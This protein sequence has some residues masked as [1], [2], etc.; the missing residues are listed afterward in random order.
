MPVPELTLAQVREI[1]RLRARHA[2][3]EVRAHQRPWGVIVEVRRHGHVVEIERFDF[4]G[5]T[6]HDQPIRLA[7]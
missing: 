3:A 7:A 1:A 4:D 5:A 6:L 2:G